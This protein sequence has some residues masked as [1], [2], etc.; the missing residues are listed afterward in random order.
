MTVCAYCKGE[1]DNER[2]PR[3]PACGARHHLQC[4]DEYGGCSQFAC[5][6]GPG[7]EG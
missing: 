3:C 2:S 5:V 4:W 7:N 1:L 6:A